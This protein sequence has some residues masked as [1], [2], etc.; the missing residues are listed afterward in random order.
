MNRI[1][2]NY[3]LKVIVLLGTYFVTAWIGLQF[4]AVGGFATLVWPPAGIAFAFTLLWG[5]RM[6]PGVFAGAFLINWLTGAP[7]YSAVGM[8]IGNTLEAC[9]AAYLLNNSDGFNRSLRT[10]RDVLRFLILGAFSSTAIAATIGTM[11]LFAGQVI[12]SSAFVE[13][14]MAWWIGDMLGLQLVGSFLII[15]SGVRIGLK[16][17][18]HKAVEGTFLLLMILSFAFLIF[19]YLDAR[20][21]PVT[22]IVFVPIIWSAI[23]FGQ[24]GVVTVAS[25]LSAISIWGTAVGLGPFTGSG[26]AESLLYLQVFM[27]T[28]SGVGMILAAVVTE[29]KEKERLL[30]ELNQDLENRV[31]K[32]TF[33]LRR[34]QDLLD[35]SFE[36]V[37]IANGTQE[38]LIQ[39]VNKAWE[40]MTGW[41]SEEV[42]GKVNPRILK[43]GRMS[44]EFY[45]NLWGTILKGDVFSAEITNK[46]K[47]GSFYEAEINIFPITTKD[48]V[49]YYSEI[50]RDIT[51]HKK[52]ENQLAEY[53]KGLEVMV[54]E[55][56]KELK[57]K[58]DDLEKLNKFMVGRELKMVELKEQN[59]NLMAGSTK[60]KPVRKTKKK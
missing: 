50:S 38:H 55:R 19:G 10:L 27:G 5:Y 48:N 52:M 29:R 28:L 35:N 58:I 7:V 9:A 34:A 8:G 33:E 45:K 25:I 18:S 30:V 40:K 36:G 57:D 20:I 24:R 49:H 11:S 2:S 46:R 60:D 22:Y 3:F 59:K 4:D 44:Q 13:T 31:E 47:D 41:T 15:W 37:M 42:V 1:D 26:L 17:K 32:R 54:A 6:W 16:I 23:S 14:W 43:S 12:D 51:E 39:Y 21:Y 53:T 56:T